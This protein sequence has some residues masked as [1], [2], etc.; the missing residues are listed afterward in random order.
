MADKKY[1]KTNIISIINADKEYGI[2]ASLL[3]GSSK[4]EIIAA[5]V[6]NAKTSRFERV[7][8]LPAVDQAKENIIYLVPS[9]NGDGDVYDEYVVVSKDGSKTFEKIGHTDIDL[10]QYAKKGDATSGPSNN[11]TSV[12]EGYSN[13]TSTELGYNA[14]GGGTVNFSGVITNEND[15]AGSECET[16]SAEHSHEFQGTSETISFQV[17]G[18]ISNSGSHTHDFSPTKVSVIADITGYD[19]EELTRVTEVKGVAGHSHDV[20]IDTHDHS[21][22]LPVITEVTSSNDDFLSSVEVDQTANAMIGVDFGSLDV[23][24]GITPESA[25][26]IVEAGAAARNDVVTGYNNVQKNSIMQMNPGTAPTLN[27]TAKPVVSGL[28]VSDGVLSFSTGTIAGVDSWSAGTAASYGAPVEVITGLGTPS[29]VKAV[30]SIATTTGTVLRSITPSFQSVFNSVETIS[31][32]TVATSVKGTSKKALTGISKT[33]GTAAGAYSVATKTIASNVGGNHTHEVATATFTNITNAITTTAEVISSATIVA[34]THSHDNLTFGGA[35]S[36]TPKGTIGGGE[37][38]HYYKA[39][40]HTHDLSDKTA[41]VE[42][43]VAIA[44][45]SHTYTVDSHSH[46]LNN[47]THTQQ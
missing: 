15:N 2:D 18:H 14:V 44:A 11:S 13:T 26:I 45:H 38:S 23:V 28:S 39:P 22:N 17:N 7:D 21:D 47:H 3:E 19:S 25:T 16:E 37:H 27:Y 31:T 5:A 4:E 1:E 34:S 12:V 36:Y 35:T 32:A 24:A 43:S 6:E 30:E 46:T 33:T 40:S 8:A 42:V 10:S 29:T 20:V 9:E 41:E